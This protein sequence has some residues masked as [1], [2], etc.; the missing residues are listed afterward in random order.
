MSP[1][2]SLV[3]IPNPINNKKAARLGGSL[4][5]SSAFGT[6]Y[7]YGANPTPGPSWLSRRTIITMT[8]RRLGSSPDT[9]AFSAVGRAS[10]WAEL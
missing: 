4:P 3:T 6:G 8:I 9:T 2:D 10:W 5:N 1:P 7:A